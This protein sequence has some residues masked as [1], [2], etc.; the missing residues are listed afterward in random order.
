MNESQIAL[1]KYTRAKEMLDAHIKN[2]KDL[3]EKHQSYVFAVMD[4][5]NELRDAVAISKEGVSNE[6]YKVEVIPQTQAQ[7]D[8]EKVLAAI[9]KT[10]EGAIAAG[11]IQVVER[12]ARISIK[13]AQ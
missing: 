4:A 9:G 2:N 8:E 13:P 12:P 3:F 5:E 6:K 7:F 1:D 11:I 10:K